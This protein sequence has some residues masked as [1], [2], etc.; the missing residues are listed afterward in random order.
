[1][2][3]FLK[4]FIFIAFIPNA[5]ISQIYYIVNELVN[6]VRGL[7]YRFYQL[8]LIKSLPSIHFHSRLLF[9]SLPVYFN[10]AT[11]VISAFRLPLVIVVVAEV[12]G[13]TPPSTF[14]VILGIGAFTVLAPPPIPFPPISVPPSLVCT[15]GL[16]MLLLAAVSLPSPVS[17]PAP[18]PYRVGITAVTIASRN[19]PWNISPLSVRRFVNVGTASAPPA[20][21]MRH[22][23]TAVPERLQ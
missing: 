1:M 9:T 23:A 6:Q 10:S 8:N 5:T 14:P 22:S 20:A 12:I 2:R 3:I 11:P 21:V 16:T 15:N 19:P 18:A 17:S 4:C 7:R 13:G